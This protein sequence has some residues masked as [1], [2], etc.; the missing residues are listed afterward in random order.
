V[1]ANDAKKLARF[2]TGELKALANPEDAAPMQAYL[3]TDMPM[4]GVKKP[5]R[6]DLYRALKKEWVP[7]DQAAY[8]AG[9]GALWSL[10]HRE[11]KYAAIRYARDHKAFITLGALPLFERMVREG[12]WWDLVDDI[13]IN[14]VGGVALDE[15]KR[16]RAVL[17]RWLKDE[18]L[19]IRRTAIIAQL[20]HKDATD[21]ALLFD[22]CAHTMHEKVFW[23]R[24]AIGWALRD[25]AR[26]DAAA[27]RQFLLDHREGLS[28][29]S[30]R[31][32]KKGV[33]RAGLE[34]D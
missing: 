24:K 25:Y 8:D 21:A 7:D 3:K 9:V 26:T 12:A 33:V 27:V 23:I 30:F 34:L 14:L 16:M 2:V 6:K 11:E 18:D 15:P 29:L 32:A 10:P 19:W 31:E 20:K 1:K 28:G 22:F 5:A 4:F 17:K 13:A